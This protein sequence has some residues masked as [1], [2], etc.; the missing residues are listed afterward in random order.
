MRNHIGQYP[1]FRVNKFTKTICL[2]ITKNSDQGMCKP[3]Y[4]DDP[5]PLKPVTSLFSL[6][7]LL[8]ICRDFDLEQNL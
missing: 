3:G 8:Q 5:Q 4:I 1:I 6:L 2:A 7:C